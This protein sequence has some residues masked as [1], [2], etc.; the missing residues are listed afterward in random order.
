[1]SDTTWSKEMNEAY[2][3]LYSKFFSGQNI[4]RRP[5]VELLFRKID[6]RETQ[7]VELKGHLARLQAIE[8]AAIELFR[9]PALGVY[10][11]SDAVERNRL[12]NLRA[13]LGRK[14]SA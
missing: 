12:D 1:M 5:S 11:H 4:F 3:S 9:K 10:S 7:I 14:P 6:Q 13:A 8:A 2:N